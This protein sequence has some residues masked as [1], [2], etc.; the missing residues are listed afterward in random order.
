MYCYRF[1]NKATFRTLASAEGLLTEDDELITASHTFAIDEVGILTE[2][3]T[4]D[5]ET[6]EVIT[7]PV[8]LSGWHVNLIAA[9]A[10]EAWDQFL[11]V[12]NSPA[13]VFLGGP[14]QAPDTATLEAMNQ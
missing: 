2:G 6:G 1:P 12:V 4:Y 14:A 10:P 13:R 3:G 8:A 7:P 9:D 11:V 5:P